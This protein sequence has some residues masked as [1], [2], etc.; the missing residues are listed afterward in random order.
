MGNGRVKWLIKKTDWPPDSS[1]LFQSNKLMTKATLVLANSIR[2]AP[3]SLHLRR[4]GRVTRTSLLS[5]CGTGI[6][7]RGGGEPDA[8][9]CLAC[10]EYRVKVGARL[11][12]SLH[13]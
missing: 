1:E 13:A 5:L 6:G 12:W 10:M 4:N 9:L 3:A 8:P 11:A 2:D 7:G